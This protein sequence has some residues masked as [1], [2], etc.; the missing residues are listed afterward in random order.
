VAPYRPKRP[1]SQLTNASK[2]LEDVAVVAVVT[3]PVPVVED[4]VLVDADA[5]LAEPSMVQVVLVPKASSKP[6][7]S[8]R[9]VERVP[10]ALAS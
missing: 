4:P 5:W 2:G 3:V 7:R 9:S 6:L 1:L 8:M 10:V